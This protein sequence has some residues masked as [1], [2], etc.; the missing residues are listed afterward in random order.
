MKYFVTVAGKEMVVELD[1]ERVTVDGAPIDSAHLNTLPGTPIRHLLLDG[2]SH[3]LALDP[4]GRGQWAVG[5]LGEHHEVEVVDERTRHIRSLTG[6]G[7]KGSGPTTLKAPMPGLVV[8]VG[9][10]EGARVEAGTPLVVLE[11]M[12]ME[13]ELRATA[14]GVVKGVKVKAGQAVEKG[15]V[16][17][18]FEVS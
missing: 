13:N 18:E 16:L 11:A 10:E 5:Y 8:R 15:Q 7:Q 3:A 9:V 6:A 12:K 4:V 14:P 17:V 1:G 2:A